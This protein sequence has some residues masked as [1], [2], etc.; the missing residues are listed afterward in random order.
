MEVENLRR[1]LLLIENILQLIF[2]DL[3]LLLAH[4]KVWRC[5]RVAG[6]WDTS[7]RNIDQAATVGVSLTI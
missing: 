1:R 5:W 2:R 4:W 6:D 7:H 3:G